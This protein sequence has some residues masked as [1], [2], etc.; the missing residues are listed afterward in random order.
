[1]QNKVVADSE[2]L[3][4]ALASVTQR[5]ETLTAS[6]AA[7]ELESVDA[8]SRL[9][10]AEM[11]WSEATEATIEAREEGAQAKTSI[12]SKQPPTQSTPSCWRSDEKS[13]RS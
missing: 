9:A 12:W 5:A 3:A 7:A 6:L 13:A 8:R 10:E 11:A 2:G 1:M 4:E